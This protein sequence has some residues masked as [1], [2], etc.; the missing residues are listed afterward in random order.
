MEQWRK[1]WNNGNWN[2]TRDNGM[3]QWSETMDNGRN[4]GQ[5]EWIKGK[6]NETMDRNNG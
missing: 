3:K 6:Q 4:N 1:E 2:K 5:L